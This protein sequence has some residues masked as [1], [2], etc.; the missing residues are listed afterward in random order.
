MSSLKIKGSKSHSNHADSISQNDSVVNKFLQNSEN[1]SEKTKGKASLKNSGENTENKNA[2]DTTEAGNVK[3]SM[4]E[5]GNDPTTYDYSKSF[6]EQIEDW[7]QGK[8]PKNDNMLVCA[9]PD[10]FKEIGLN[11]LPVTI[12]QKHIDYALYNTKN[13]DHS[14]Y[15]I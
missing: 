3:Y 11:A 13:A 14:Q 5:S 10:V 15:I 1:N 6:A 9:T 2:S 12:N 8:I 7:K 4:K